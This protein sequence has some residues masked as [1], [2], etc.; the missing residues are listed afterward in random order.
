MRWQ[1]VQELEELVPGERIQGVS[2][3]HFPPELFADHFPSLPITPG[4]LMVE[5]GAQLSGL[6]I[7]ATLLEQ[8]RCWVF[9]VLCMILEAKFR[10]FVPPSVNLEGSAE[11]V[12]LRPEAAVCT[13]RLMR[14]GKRCV[15]MRLML[16]FDR[17]ERAGKGDVERLEG[18]SRSRFASLASPWQPAESI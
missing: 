12:E 14:H 2:S 18:F 6:L 16:A 1:L 7:Q 17:S 5:M 9:P 11:L 8:Q 4:V 13:A 3:T 10:T 15:T